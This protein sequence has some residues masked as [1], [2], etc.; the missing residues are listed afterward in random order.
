MNP[1]HGT[2]DQCLA[3][4]AEVEA[5]DF[6]L[7]REL[8]QLLTADVAGD[9]AEADNPR[10]YLWLA[11]HWA[12]RQG[13]S[14]LDLT[15]IA[16]QTL[17]ADPETRKP[18]HRFAEL[19]QLRSLLAGLD[20]TAAAGRALVREADRLYLR[21]YWQFEGEVA[22]ALRARLAPLALDP[23]QLALARQTIARLFATAP[24]ATSEPDWQA[25]AVANALNRR[26][27]I[28]SGGPGT[29]KTYTVTRLL[30]TLQAVAGGQLR[31][32]MAAPTGKAK[33]RLQESIG[34]AKAQLA[35]SG[36]EPQWLAAI[37]PEAHTL[38]GL[39]GVRPNSTQLRHH[40]ANPLAVD[41]LLIDEASMVDLP[42]MAR[43]L[44][45][46]PESARLVL[47]G[48]ANQLPSI[49][50]GSVLSDLAPLP[51]GGYSPAAAALVEQ[52][53]GY[54]VPLATSADGGEQAAADH[55][56]LLRHSHRF[57]GAGGIGQLAPAVIGL[58]A[59]GS[60]QQLQGVSH[61]NSPAA[62]PDGQLSLIALAEWE[63][64][65]ERAT[66]HYF[67]GIAK[68]AQPAAAFA[69]LAAFRVLVPTRVGPL[70]V[71]ALNLQIETQ[72]ARHNGQ[73]RPGQ[74]Y[75]G[76]PIM[77]TRN[78]HG[79]NLFNGDVGLVWR[80]E[81]G[82]LEACFEQE[83]GIRRI[84]LGLLPAVESV[85][86]MTIHKTQ[87]SEFG[88]VALLLPDAARRLLSP[89]LIYTGITRAKGHCYLAVNEKLWREALARRAQRWSG[90]AAR[91]RAGGAAAER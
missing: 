42:M 12:L 78:H 32:A 37:P 25:V 85:Y 8:Q 43:I 63:R 57:D 76:R 24:T 56:S 14:C 81:A 31:I 23:A 51:H 13:H 48:D 89:E 55:V 77:I 90:L 59:Q 73:I 68:A 52:L 69:Q 91:V 74:H 66:A 75:H 20:L 41:L 72:L 79:L 87:G 86:A 4:L 83:Q 44:R 64:W 71:D 47:V 50:V 39:L 61:T 6:F 70:G 18:G 15:R 10:F 11:L 36:F 82:V 17:W 67:R 3:A 58:D 88:Q 26:F 5:I 54:A 46:L 28:L 2:S 30:A 7:A 29:G 1:M 60:W 45:A 21:R 22:T 53:C 49:A 27:A 84:N 34:A 38:H 9:G 35:A 62:A 16:G 80:N 19:A 65:L 40:A 33:Q